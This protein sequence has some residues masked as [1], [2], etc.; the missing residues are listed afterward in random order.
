MMNNLICVLCFLLLLAWFVNPPEVSA[1]AAEYTPAPQSPQTQ[2]YAQP[3][4]Y[5]QYR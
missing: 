4:P 3:Q 2:G 5:P 1:P